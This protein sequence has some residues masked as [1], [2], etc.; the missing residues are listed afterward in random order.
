METFL[1]LLIAIIPLMCTG[2]NLCVY[3]KLIQCIETDLSDSKKK[4][5]EIILIL[6]RIN[7]R[8]SEI[9]RS[10]LA[11]QEPLEATK[12]IKP[13]NWNSMKEAFKGP[14]RIEGNERD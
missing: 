9:S 2:I 13:N 11:R 8:Q 6:D 10:M 4:Y 12:P 3:Y 1:L 5:E 7:Q 14:V